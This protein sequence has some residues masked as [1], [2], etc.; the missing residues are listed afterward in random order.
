MRFTT[1]LPTTLLALSPISAL[2]ACDCTHNS[3]AGRW[4]DSQYSP[5]D[6]V[7]FLAKQDG[8][9]CYSASGQGKLC[10]MYS[11][12]NG[13]TKPIPKSDRATLEECLS[14]VS[15]K[16]QS[17]HGGSMFLWTQIS[18]ELASKSKGTVTIVKG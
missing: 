4:K 17:Q 14:G 3:D 6:V 12:V 11:G 16:E 13:D 5:A 18:C 2:A 7:K 9:G 1:G 8:G 10:V 15:A